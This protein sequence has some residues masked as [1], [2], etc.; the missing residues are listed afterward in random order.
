MLCKDKL[1]QSLK[2]EQNII[3]KMYLNELLINWHKVE[4]AF[5]LNKNSRLSVMINAISAYTKN[6]TNPKFRYTSAKKFGFTEDHDVFQGHYLYDI[7][8]TIVKEAGIKEGKNSLYIKNKPF[9]KSIKFENFTYKKGTDKSKF[10]FYSTGKYYHV[11][12]DFDFN[13]KLINQK[14]YNKAKLS[15]PL[16]VFYIEKHYNDK[17]FEEIK[18]LKK[19]TIAINPNAL[20]ICLTE[21][22]DRKYTKYYE[23]IK[24]HL[25]ILR[26]NYKDDPY[27]DLQPQVALALFNKIYN[28]T[29]NE[30]T[31]F[32]KI[33]EFGNI[34]IVPKTVPLPDTVEIGEDLE[35]DGDVVEADAQDEGVS[36]EEL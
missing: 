13:Y 3:N 14:Y 32:D 24:E 22:V 18:Q 17:S 2:N 8:E 15:V 20:F 19:D 28:F 12:I 36:G 1:T 7:V 11:G 26:A 25:Y 6:L 16:I 30:L 9:H 4:T 27:N 23:E 31:T 10:E 5:H 34:N 35:S 33:V 29:Y 21:S